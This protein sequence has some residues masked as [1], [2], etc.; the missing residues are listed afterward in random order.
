MLTEPRYPRPV[1]RRPRHPRQWSTTWDRSNLF[2]YTNLSPNPINF[3]SP[4]AIG[5]ADIVITDTSTYQSVWGF[6]ASLSA[7]PA[8]TVA[9]PSRLLRAAPLP[10]RAPRARGRAGWRLQCVMA[11]SLRTEC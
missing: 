11:G 10:L 8:L 2:N 9:M 4:G 6:G 3:K 7:Y 5:Q 1:R